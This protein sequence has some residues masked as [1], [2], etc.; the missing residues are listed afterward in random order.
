MIAN[1]GVMNGERAKFIAQKIDALK[2]E[3][4]KE[5]LWNEYVRKGLITS[6]V[7]KQVKSLLK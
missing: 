5:A 7:A 6:N 4:E 3:E 1:L 2:T